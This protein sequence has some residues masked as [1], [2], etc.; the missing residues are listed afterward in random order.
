M[1]EKLKKLKSSLKYINWCML[2]DR[3]GEVFACDVENQEELAFKLSVL[4]DIEGLE[5]ILIEKSNGT[6]YLSI[7][8][9][10]K[11]V[12]LDSEKKLNIPL[13]RM[14]L[15]RIV[16]VKQ[17]KKEIVDKIKTEPKKATS[18][19]TKDENIFRKYDVIDKNADIMNIITSEYFVRGISI[20]NIIVEFRNMFEQLLSQNDRANRT[21]VTVATTLSDGTLI[22]IVGVLVHYSGGLI[23]RR[24]KA[25]EGKLRQEIGEISRICAEESASMFGIQTKVRCFMDFII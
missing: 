15:K 17:E 4:F 23:R 3:N 19:L 22:F 25:L 5:E 21:N 9:G 12:Y 1:K 6:S 11:I 8:N 20:G 2:V 16:N 13:L 14:Y 18:P 7:Y 10:E 24:N